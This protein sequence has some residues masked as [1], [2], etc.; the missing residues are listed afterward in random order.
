MNSIDGPPADNAAIG[1]RVFHVWECDSS[2]YAIK[3]Y[4]CFVHDGAENR[5]L[6]IDENGCSRDRSIL[7]EL[8]YDPNLNFIYTSSKVFK[9]SN[10]NKMFFN[11]LL[12][13]CPKNDQKC[14]EAVP[15]ACG[16]AERKK[17][18]SSLRNGM[19]QLTLNSSLPYQNFKDLQRE[20]IILKDDPEDPEGFLHA[21]PPQPVIQYTGKDAYLSIHKT[22]FF[23]IPKKGTVPKRATATRLFLC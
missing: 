10:S 21:I 8:T 23:Q 18:F 3:V 15:P 22:L 2:N 13:M 5:Y 7:P 14:K 6:I 16:N 1:D 19:I 9:F 12:Y 4:Q 20:K 17:R 11:C